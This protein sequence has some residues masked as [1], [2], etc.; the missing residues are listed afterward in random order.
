MP[1]DVIPRARKR[2]VTSLAAVAAL[3]AALLPALMFTTPASAAN[4]CTPAGYTAAGTADLLNLNL[5]D[6]GALGL[7][8]GPIA[9]VTIG[10]AS[11]DMAHAHAD[12]A[13][14][15]ADYLSAKL[16]GINVPSSLLN[17]HAEQIA[18]PTHPAPDRHSLVAVN[19]GLL[20]LG[21]GNVS[22]AAGKNGPYGCGIADGSASVADLAVLPGAGRHSLIALPDNLNGFAGASMVTKNGHLASYANAGAG[23]ADLELFHGTPAA[24]GVKVITEPA[25]TGIATGTKST[26]SISYRSPVLDVTLP[27][28]RQVTLDDTHGSVDI[29]TAINLPMLLGALHLPSL[30]ALPVSLKKAALE[31]RLSLGSLTSSVTKTSVSGSAATLRLQVLLAPLGTDSGILANVTTGG[32]TVLDLGIGELAVA[33]TAPAAVATTPSPSPSCS[34]SGYGYGCGTPCGTTGGYGYGS[35]SCATPTPTPSPSR[36]H[37]PKPTPSGTVAATTSGNLPLTGS[38]TAMYAGSAVIL[39]ALGRF[40]MVVA[41]RR[42]TTG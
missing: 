1:N 38:N 42:R 12:S 35:P 39:L 7:G 5:L 29:G 10:H 6:V 37:L 8:H 27:G 36:S 31:I 24:I 41:R 23:L 2:R 9:N 11:A 3:G 18:P 19:N 16:A 4:P 15:K 17:T 13:S 20:H 33:A 32:T 22:A 34:T 30:P 26:S 28:G 21:V 14:A 40:L 25:L